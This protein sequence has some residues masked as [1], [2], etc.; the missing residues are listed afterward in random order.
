[1]SGHSHWAGIKYKKAAADKKRGKVFS[2]LAKDIIV[3]AKHGGGDPDGNITLRAAV[4]AAKA[5]NM[6][7]DN[8][9][10][11]IKRGTGEIDGVHYEEIVYEG[12]G[13]QGVSIMAES[14]TDNKNRTVAEVRKI[15]E[16]N[17]GNLGASVA[18]NFSQ[19]GLILI[20]QQEGVDEESLT[21]LAIEG[22]A[23]DVSPSGEYF[24]IITA[25]E[26][27]DSMKTALEAAGIQWE[28]A[29]VTLIPKNT[30]NVEDLSVARKILNLLEALDDHDD[31]QKVHSNCEF[32]ENMEE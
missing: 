16:V 4:D 21:E 1:M 18:W 5:A 29:E 24:E 27:F 22:G 31:I 15:F 11:A 14:L 3:A 13:P 7:K 25:P 6:P 28:T 32:P 23:E 20:P 26:D 8:I 19:K 10:R 2:K 30:V 12:V 17:G 9:D